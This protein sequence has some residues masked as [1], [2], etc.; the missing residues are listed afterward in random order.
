MIAIQDRPFPKWS[1]G[2][3]K[4]HDGY[5]LAL[6]PRPVVTRWVGISTAQPVLVQKSFPVLGIPPSS[7]TRVPLFA[8][9]SE[10]SLEHSAV[11]PPA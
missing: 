9:G 6:F 10:V 11:S 8:V 7:E 2:Q 4:V 1:V 3:H 5:A